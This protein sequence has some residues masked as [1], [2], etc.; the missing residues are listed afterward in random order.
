MDEH[1]RRFDS[2]RCR[3]PSR[4]KSF[5]PHV[6]ELHVLL[7]LYTTEGYRNQLQLPRRPRLPG[8]RSQILRLNAKQIWDN[9]RR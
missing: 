8:F 3:Y 5:E 6:P 7:E 9:S 2:V 1:S 4:E